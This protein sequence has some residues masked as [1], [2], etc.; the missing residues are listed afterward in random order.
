MREILSAKEKALLSA[1]AYF[2]I[3]E[4]PV[5]AFEAWQ[6]SWFPRGAEQLFLSEALEILETLEK[7]EYIESHRGF[8]CLKHRSNIVHF[9]S[10]RSL[11]AERKYAKALR[12]AKLLR[13]IPGVRMVAVC[14]NLAISNARDASDIDFFIITQTGMAWVARF[15]AALFAKFFHARPEQGRTRD[16]ICLSFFVAEDALDLRPVLLPKRTDGAEDIYMAYWIRQL[17]PLYDAGEFYRKF[18]E[19]NG[20]TEFFLPNVLP[21]EM[22]RRCVSSPPIFFLKT[23]FEWIFSRTFFSTQFKHYQMKILP[24]ALTLRAEKNDHAVVLSDRML[25]LHSE[26]RRAVY[27]H[28][29][30][31]RCKLFS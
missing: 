21:C 27:A 25:K 31:E 1:I 15:F 26:D 12:Y 16:T 29:F 2:D 5:T 10:E 7:K 30:H 8:F 17:V 18:L 19:A 13:C 24:E 11:F 14:N 3:F 4:Y 6:W 20:W 28:K 9:R 23:A 22:P